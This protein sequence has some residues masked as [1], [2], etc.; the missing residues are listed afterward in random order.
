MW[1]NSLNLN[2]TIDVLLSILKSG[3]VLVQLNSPGT[4]W[5]QYPLV[6]G[7]TDFLMR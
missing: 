4:V 1:C 2:R 5:L 3:V 7:D 6:G